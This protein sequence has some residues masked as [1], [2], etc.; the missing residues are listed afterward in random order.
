LGSLLSVALSSAPAKREQYITI[1]RG[2]TTTK[3]ILYL[4]WGTLQIA[5]VEGDIIVEPTYVIIG[6]FVDNLAWFCNQDMKWGV[7]DA[8]GC[9]VIEPK[10]E[11]EQNYEFQP[12]YFVNGYAV[13]QLVDNELIIV[14]EIGK[15]TLLNLNML[16][17]GNVSQVLPN[18]TMLVYSVENDSANDCGFIDV[19]GNV[20]TEAVYSNWYDVSENM[21]RVRKNG[22]YGFIDKNG[23]EVIPCIYDDAYDFV[24]STACVK[25]DGSILYINHE[26]TVVWNSQ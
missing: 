9:V 6:S 17:I 20:L 15:E 13:R 22:K 1:R 12:V 7:M 14:D 23:Q 21:I 19:K 2:R 10:Y 8:N 11:V 24:N 18:T 5:D 16:E 3:Q 4:T 25:L 26:G